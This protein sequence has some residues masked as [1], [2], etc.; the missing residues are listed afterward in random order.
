MS[1]IINPITKAPFP[2]LAALVAGNALALPGT[3]VNVRAAGAAVVVKA[4]SPAVQSM[5]FAVLDAD[6]S[7]AAQPIVIDG[8]G[9]NI[10]GGLTAQISNANDCAV[11]LFD[12]GAWRPVI[13][14]WAVDLT[15]GERILFQSPQLS[16]ATV[17]A[18][19]AVTQGD[20]SSQ[21]VPA[22]SGPT[23]WWGADFTLPW[24]PRTPSVGTFS[25]N[26]NLIAQGVAPSVGGVLANGRA[27]ALFNGT[28]QGLRS[29][30]GVGVFVGGQASNLDPFTAMVFG[31]ATALVAGGTFFSMPPLITDDGTHWALTVDNA[32][33]CAGA[34]GG[35]TDQTPKIL[36]GAGVYFR[37]SYRYDG[38]NL[39]CTVS[40]ASGTTKSTIARTVGPGVQRSLNPAGL[41]LGVQGDNSA[42]LTGEEFEAL[43]WNRCL[44]DAEDA[45]FNPYFNA[46]FAKGLT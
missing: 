2:V 36:I 29:A 1:T 9:A 16:L 44:S 35:G 6:G 23:G 32:G 11:Y 42:R 4:P 26:G 21:V 24:L 33:I 8:N 15:N 31:R 41:R 25:G 27:P 38:T 7:A 19:T 3:Q 37:A 18:A 34:W 14:T 40:Q 45:S 20:A 22:V 39:I 28:T 12:A 46:R 30:A 5:I 17:A 13:A 10:A 43:T